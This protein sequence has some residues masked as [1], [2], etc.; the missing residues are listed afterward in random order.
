MSITRFRPIPV[1]ALLLS[2]VGCIPPQEKDKKKEEAAASARKMPDRRGI[3]VPTLSLAELAEPP[4]GAKLLNMASAEGLGYPRFPDHLSGVV[5]FCAEGDLWQVS[6]K[7]GLARRLTVHRG[8]ELFPK[9][10]PDGKWLAFSGDYD[11]NQD[12]FLM[13]SVGGVPRR[14]TFH[15]ADDQVIGWTPDGSSILFRSRRHHPHGDWTLHTVPVKG[16]D[17]VMLPLDRAARLTYEP[18]GK[19]VAINLTSREFRNW[20][21]YAGGRAA[22]ILVGDLEGGRF[23]KL[24]TFK[25]TNAFPM[26]HKERIYFLSDRT[27]TMNIWSMTASGEDLKQHTRHTDY[28][29]RFP[30]LG[31]GKIVYQHKAGLRILDPE[32]GEDRP[33]DVRVVSDALR[34]RT[35]FTNPARYLRR[36]ALSSD[37]SALAL[38]IRG[39]LHLLPAVKEGV[40]VRVSWSSSSRE[41]GVAFSPDGKELATISDRT[42]ET[43]IHVFDAEGKKP[44]R[45]VTSGGNCFKYPPRWSP[46]GKHLVF[47]D[48]ENRLFLVPAKG[49]GNKAP[50][51]VDSSPHGRLSEYR[52]SPDSRYLAYTK[53]NDNYFRSVFLY[54]IEK[55]KITRITDEFHYDWSP[56]WSLDGKYLAFLSDRTINPLLDQMDRETILDKMT[57]PY[58]VLLASKTPSPFLPKKPGKAEPKKQE[59]KKEAGKKTPEK[60]VVDL[61]GI[62]NRIV[63]VPVKAGNLDGLWMGDGVI[64]YSRHP[65]LGMADWE[66]M[67]FGGGSSFDLMHFDMEK[68]KESSYLAGVKGYSVSLDGKKMAVRLLKGKDGPVDLYVFDLKPKPPQEKELAEHLIPVR[69][70]RKE[71][72][73]LKEWEQIFNETWR[74]MRDFFFAPDMAKVDWKAMWKKYR[75]LLPHVTTRR[76]LSD[77]LGEMVSELSLGHTYIWG[78]DLRGAGRVSVGLLGADLIPHPSGFY[79]F[80]KIYSGANWDKKRFSPLTL[81]HVNVSEGQFLI[82]IDGRLVR[83]GENVS[84]RL[85]KAGGELVTLTVNTTPSEAGGRDVEVRTLRSERHVRYYTWIRKNLEHVSKKTGGRVGYLHIPDMMTS[86]M[87]EFDRL[88]YPQVRKQGL[89]V[90]AR[91]NRGG[92]VSQIMVKR[93]TRKILSWS[94]ARRGYMGPYPQNTLNGKLVVLT[95][96]SAGSDGDIFPRA[97]QV[98][99]AGPVIGTRTWGGVV[100]INMAFPLVDRGVSTRPTYFAWWEPVRR[101]RLE[102][103]GVTPD[104]EVENDPAQAFKGV[105]AQLER[106]ISVILGLLA[107]D[108][109]QKP[110]LSGSPDKRKETWVGKYGRTDRP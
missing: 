10:S 54:D 86:G 27:G 77:L 93:L 21:R 33:V 67:V 98:A 4:G 26:W 91:W 47:S 1:A 90:D 46:D 64:L 65:T 79:Q 101:W 23:K 97:I 84:S 48:S 83:A 81:S 51:L 74:M 14:L 13:P 20:K 59:K 44:E 17:P 41:Q 40:K 58:L 16:G 70:I 39:D 56:S 105:D 11:G 53:P 63:E 104:I 19:R 92:F 82:R 38:E 106:G 6:A 108:P 76:E 50:L 88:F 8:E 18:S 99:K 109:P 52:F 30:S 42:G 7:G 5:V 45:Q 12:V 100:G 66:E 89:I 15:P 69:K 31:Q 72:D 85:Q 2:M 61:D 96:E 22:Q 71:V 60:V 73:P 3:A 34:T 9:F 25:G 62:E 78:G 49:T 75:K 107:K 24:T 57:K 95:N 80:K 37:G 102:G 32:K 29:A 36:F 103:E 55:K 87:V 35:R 28:D 43:E 110:D 68:R 94:R